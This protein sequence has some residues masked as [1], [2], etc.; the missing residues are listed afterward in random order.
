MLPINLSVHN[1]EKCAES[2]TLNLKLQYNRLKLNI[3][4]YSPCEHHILTS[5]ITVRSMWR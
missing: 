5:D 4:L 2:Q 1:L 3:G